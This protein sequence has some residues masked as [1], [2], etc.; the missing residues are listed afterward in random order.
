MT[1]EETIDEAVRRV[2]ARLAPGAGPG[3]GSGTGALGDFDEI[4]AEFRRL[5]HDHKW[6]LCYRSSDPP[7]DV[8]DCWCGARKSVPRGVGA[9]PDDIA[10]DVK[11]GGSPANA[12]NKLSD[13]QSPQMALYLTKE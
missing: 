2:L 8:H 3:S 5:T 13:L 4:R 11:P 6:L 12:L 9:R 10:D 1:R 7:V